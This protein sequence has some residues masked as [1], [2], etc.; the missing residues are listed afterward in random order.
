MKH[1]TAIALNKRL[2]ARVES[3]T[4]DEADAPMTESAD[5]FLCPQRF[6][7]ERRQFFRD[8]P[9]V[10]GFAGELKNGAYMTADV[11]DVPVLVTRD[12][13][14]VLRAFVNA[15]AHRGA[16]VAYGR[17]ERLKLSCKFHGWTYA[18][19]GTLAGRPKDECFEAADAACGL[20]VLPVSDRSGLI[21][22]GIDPAMPQSAVDTFLADI[23]TEF[24]GFGFRDMH[25]IETR[26]LEVDANWKLVASLSHESYHFATLHR[27][28]V[29]AFLHANAVCDTFGRHSRWAFPMKGIER[30]KQLP[31]AQWPTTVEGAINHTLFPGTVAIT[32]PEDAQII[33][34]EP[35][36]HPGHSVI[37]YT[38]VCRH[39]EKIDGA[40]AAYEFGGKVFETEDLPAAAECQQG[41][42]V[43]REQV[44]I[45]RNEPIVQFWHRL[46]RKELDNR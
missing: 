28:S 41:I 44:F 45:G 13:E 12:G 24:S 7:R 32:N 42:A 15:C 38:G 6:A 4:T 21:V 43:G 17:G 8:T 20:T 18:L 26:R 14:G 25:A 9:Q 23:E 19:D 46:W 37:Y 35:G 11:L 39:P 27:D 22:V 30:L 3:N 10:V 33:R 31:E 29:A 2:I 36:E 16:R 5:V 34:V 1:E 40:R